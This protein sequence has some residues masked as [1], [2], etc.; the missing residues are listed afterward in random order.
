[1]VGSTMVWKLCRRLIFETLRSTSLCADSKLFDAASIS[2][3]AT[4]T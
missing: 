2:S 1:M 3:D 4:E